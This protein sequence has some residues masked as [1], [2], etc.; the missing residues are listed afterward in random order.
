MQRWR[1]ERHASPRIARG[2]HRGGLMER[3][4]KALQH[5]ARRDRVQEGGM[6]ETLARKPSDDGPGGNGL[7][8]N[9]H[10]WR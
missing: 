1:V 9:G 8:P 3:A 6:Q 4:K 7:C 5:C 2:V 10:A